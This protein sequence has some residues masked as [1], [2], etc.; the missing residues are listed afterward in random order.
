MSAYSHLTILQNNSFTLTPKTGEIISSQ[1]NVQ[2]SYFKSD[3]LPA[4]VNDQ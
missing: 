1:L 3:R 2:P 4:I